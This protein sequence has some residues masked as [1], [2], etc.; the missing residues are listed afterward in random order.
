MIIE[1]AN[2]TY[3]TRNEENGYYQIGILRDGV[4]L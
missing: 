2:G 1:T 4:T 3:R